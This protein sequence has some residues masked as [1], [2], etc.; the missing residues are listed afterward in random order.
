MATFTVTNVERHANGSVWAYGG[1]KVAVAGPAYDSN[2][3]SIDGYSKD[4][5]AGDGSISFPNLTVGVV[6]TWT[7]AD[8]SQE[9]FQAGAAGTFT[10]QAITVSVAAP[11]QPYA[12]PASLTAEAAARA[13]ADASIQTQLGTKAPLPSGVTPGYVAT[14]GSDG[15]SI[16][17]AAPTGGGGLT[18]I[19]NGSSL[20]LTPSGGT[21][22]TDNGSSLTITA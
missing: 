21:S 4:Q 20:S 17:Y 19:D 11:G 7:H 5:T 13:A 9:N 2:G 22:V 10:L 8:G 6:Y 15:N 12:T 16:T 18:A 14:V 1:V 3:A